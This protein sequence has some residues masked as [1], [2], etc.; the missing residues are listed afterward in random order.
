VAKVKQLSVGESEDVE[1]G[2]LV[3]SYDKKVVKLQ[4]CPNGPC[5]T[6]FGPSVWRVTGKSAGTTTVSLK[7]EQ[8][9]TSYQF[10]V[11]EK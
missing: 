6:E 3:G 10:I 1:G 9:T 2:E 5:M 7:G 8:T 11:S 4:S